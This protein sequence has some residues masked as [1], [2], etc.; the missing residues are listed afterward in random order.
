V[1]SSRVWIEE[2]RRGVGFGREIRW[3]M[4]IAR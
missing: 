3:R 1:H 4:E 2:Y